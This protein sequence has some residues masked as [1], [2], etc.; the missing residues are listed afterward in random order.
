[1]KKFLTILLIFLPILGSAQYRGTTYT[2]LRI[3]YN[4]A[5]S[6][7]SQATT[8]NKVKREKITG[9][10]VKIFCP[11]SPFVP[12]YDAVVEICG[13]NNGVVLL[14][15]ISSN[16]EFGVSPS[17]SYA[18]LSCL[19]IYAQF[20]SNW[21]LLPPKYDVLGYRMETNTHFSRY[22]WRP[23]NLEVKLSK[24]TFFVFAPSI[25]S[26]TT[27][28]CLFDTSENSIGWE[29][30]HYAL[31]ERFNEQFTDYKD[32]GIGLHAGIN[33]SGVIVCLEAYNTK[34]S[35]SIGLSIQF[36]GFDFF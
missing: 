34:H 11:W 25:F 22:G 6:Q 18:G 12:P 20:G 8:S 36:G 16:N 2:D 7:S 21:H 5:V 9:R 14:N 10:K 17:V 19:G 26:E 23:F 3:P 4:A 33:F 13:A 24:H 27:Y 29:Y 15:N 35:F 31:R 28:H 32:C 1:M 30:Q